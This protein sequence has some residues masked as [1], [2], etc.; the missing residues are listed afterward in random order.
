MRLTGG[1][2]CIGCWIALAIVLVGGACHTF[3]NHS[4]TPESQPLAVLCRTGGL[5]GAD[6]RI[7]LYADGSFDL[8]RLS[9]KNAGKTTHSHIPP[10]SLDAYKVALRQTLELSASDYPPPGGS[11]DAYLFSVDYA[12]RQVRWSDVN[13]ELP[14]PLR[15]LSLLFNMTVMLGTPAPKSSVS[16]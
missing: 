9:G 10:E 13:E 5:V 14:D 15:R 12:G 8:A 16:P 11:A 2:W 3:S 6:D 1:R 7:T 4:R